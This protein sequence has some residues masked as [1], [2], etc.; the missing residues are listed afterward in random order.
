[1]LS[2]EDYAW[3][4]AILT[5]R[6]TRYTK[7]A[8]RAQAKALSPELVLHLHREANRSLLAASRIL[9]GLE[10]A[11]VD[12]HFEIWPKTSSGPGVCMFPGCRAIAVAFAYVKSACYAHTFDPWFHGCTPDHHKHWDEKT[13]DGQWVCEIR[14]RTSVA[15][16]EDGAE[17]TMDEIESEL[18]F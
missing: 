2:S 11:P 18:P 10:V 14:R 12:A 9:R 15:P 16:A 6:A 4:A 17:A 8:V 5:R 3:L 13:L 7:K 1:M